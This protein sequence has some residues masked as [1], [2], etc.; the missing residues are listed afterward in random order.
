M[1]RVGQGSMLGHGASQRVCK[2]G[3]SGLLSHTCGESLYC[4][5]WPDGKSIQEKLCPMCVSDR[6]WDLTVQY[7]KSV[8][9]EA[10]ER[11]SPG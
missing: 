3:T 5:Q 9:E 11:L 4:K 8:L 6:T 1:L 10:S 7:K 2:Q